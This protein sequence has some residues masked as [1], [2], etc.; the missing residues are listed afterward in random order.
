MPPTCQDII[1]ARSIM[2]MPLQEP[3][4]SRTDPSGHPSPRSDHR[5]AIKLDLPKSAT[6]SVEEAG[7]LL[8]IGRSAAYEAVRRGEIP[9]LPIGRRYR[10]PVPRLLALLGAGPSA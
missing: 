10:V 1:A 8:G 3:I 9:V 7:Q 4:S 2:S 5:V 6:I